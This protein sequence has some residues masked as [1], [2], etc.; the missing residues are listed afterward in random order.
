MISQYIIL[1]SH[2]THPKLTALN[3]SYESVQFFLLFDG[4][5]SRKDALICTSRRP[6][7]KK[8]G[9]TEAPFSRAFVLRVKRCARRSRSEPSS[10]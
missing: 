8:T 2:H 10:R 7:L 4:D 5:A 1:K 9:K 3:E 6:H